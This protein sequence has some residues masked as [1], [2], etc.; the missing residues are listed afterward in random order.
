MA[1]LAALYFQPLPEV[2]AGRRPTQLLHAVLLSDMWQIPD[3]TAAA[4]QALVDALGSTDSFSWGRLQPEDDSDGTSILS[5]VRAMLQQAV[6]PCLLPVFSVLLAACTAGVRRLQEASTRT[7]KPA[8]GV[9]SL[10]A[11]IKQLLLSVLGDLEAVWADAELR[12][13]LLALPPSAMATLLSLDNLKVCCPL[14][15]S[16]SMH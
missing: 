1:V 13:T 9:A 8:A 7:I 12:K 15:H 4:V 10:K 11:A 16:A 5:V 14:S 6:S 3:I 2:L